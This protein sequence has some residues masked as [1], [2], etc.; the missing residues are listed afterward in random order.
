MRMAFGPADGN[1]KFFC[2]YFVN[3]GMAE[4]LDRPVRRPIGGGSSRNAAANR[5]GE[6]AQVFFEGR[7]AQGRLD[8]LGRK[9]RARFFH[10]ASSG[11]FR[12][13]TCE[14]RG[15]QRRNLSRNTYREKE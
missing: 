2:V 8:H 4:C 5:V 7:W 15:L 1:R 14:R 12:D 3:A 10:R 6:I 9:L 11:T 13:L